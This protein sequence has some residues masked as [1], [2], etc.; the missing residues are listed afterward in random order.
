MK[1]Y[2]YSHTCSFTYLGINHSVFTK[3]VSGL[4][5]IRFNNDNKQEYY[6]KTPEKLIEMYEKLKKSKGDFGVTDLIFGEEIEVLYCDGE[7][8]YT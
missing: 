1:K 5:F 6:N 7:L 8:Q 4:L 3:I 2:K